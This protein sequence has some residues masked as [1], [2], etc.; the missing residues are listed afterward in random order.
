MN[1][2]TLTEAAKRV[3]NEKMSMEEKVTKLLLKYGNN[4]DDVKDM[5]K[6]HFKVTAKNYPDFKAAK[7]AEFIRSIY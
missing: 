5:M 7:L 2:E 1:N 3:L 6:K 4:P